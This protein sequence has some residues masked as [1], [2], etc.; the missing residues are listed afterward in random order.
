MSTLEQRWAE[1]DPE[2][3]LR[4]RIAYLEN[5][6][7]AL[8]KT[9]NETEI[10]KMALTAALQIEEAF[11]GARSTKQRRAQIQL[12]VRWNM[13]TVLYGEHAW[14]KYDLHNISEPLS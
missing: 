7:D 11:V 8:V 2:G 14:N 4:Q 6:L 12:I 9:F 3:Y 1:A 10:N 13:E 5:R